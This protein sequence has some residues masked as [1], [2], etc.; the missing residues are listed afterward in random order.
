MKRG[1][2]RSPG[3]VR[4]Q[5]TVELAIGATIWVTIVLLGLWLSEVSFLSVK[6]QEASAAAVWDATGRQVDDFGASDNAP[7]DSLYNAAVGGVTATTS[8]R[9]ADFDGL[10]SS[11]SSTRRLLAEGRVTDVTCAPGA[12]KTSIAFD[13]PGATSYDDGSGAVPARVNKVL[14]T[15]YKQRPATVCSARA[16]ATPY[17]LPQHFIDQG[18]KAWFD[19]PLRRDLAIELCGAG[20][21]H[22]SSCDGRYAVLLGDWALDGAPR[23]NA[24]KNLML[25]REGHQDDQTGNLPYKEMVRQLFEKSGHD[26]HANQGTPQASLRYLSKLANQGAPNGNNETQFVMS[27]AGVEADYGDML[28]M[29]FQ[30]P[31]GCAA[32][33]FNTAGTQPANGNPDVPAPYINWSQLRHPCFLGL[34]GCE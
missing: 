28:P 26:Y 16:V 24:T 22:G 10:D 7:A 3:G 27:Y 15:Y 14:Q 29:D 25:E 32:C 8:Q 1:L 31:P 19:T 4:G 23:S 11:R 20:R 21:A 30:I 34:E 5:A 6:V 2:R 12:G 33:H 17:Q 18:S 9:Y 13:V